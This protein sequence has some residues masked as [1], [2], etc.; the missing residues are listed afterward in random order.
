MYSFSLSGCSFFTKTKRHIKTFPLSFPQ[1]DGFQAAL[2]PPPIE[3]HA[4]FQ[5]VSLPHML[6]C[7]PT[8]VEF[9]TPRLKYTKRGWV[10]D[11]ECV[12]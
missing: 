3:L 11:A 8:R 2:P 6:R 4:S 12:A 10:T 7:F 9:Q 1:M 5:D